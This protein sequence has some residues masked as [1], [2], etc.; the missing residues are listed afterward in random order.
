MDRAYLP[1]IVIPT[2]AA[3]HAL[4]SDLRRVALLAVRAILRNRK[5][6]EIA[7]QQIRFRKHDL[8]FSSRIGSLGDLIL[9]VDLGDPRLSHRLVLEADLRRA[10]QPPDWRSPIRRR[11]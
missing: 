6:I 7:H 10:S 8:A 9:E 4:G 1:I 11:R 5:G 2:H 3:R